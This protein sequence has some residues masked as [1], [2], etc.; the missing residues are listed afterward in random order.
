MKITYEYE[1]DVHRRDWDALDRRR[2]EIMLRFKTPGQAIADPSLLFPFLFR[3]FR[4]ERVVDF[5]RSQFF[6]IT[7]FSM[8]FLDR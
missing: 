7:V 3:T 5:L 1:M 2:P 8:I 6:G 4:T